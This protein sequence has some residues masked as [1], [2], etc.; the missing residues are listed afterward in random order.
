[1]ML[2]WEREHNLV[3]SMSDITG[4]L[5]NLHNQKDYE[6]TAGGKKNNRAALA[7]RSTV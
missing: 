7:T 5:G 1:M 3:P 6:I 2:I 4:N